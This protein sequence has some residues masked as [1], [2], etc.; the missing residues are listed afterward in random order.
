MHVHILGICGTFMAGI[1]QIAQ[2]KGYRVTGS[3]ENV[4]PPMSTLLEKSGITLTTGYDPT[5]LDTNPDLVIIGN[6]MSRGNPCVE[7]VLRD[8][9]PYIS[10]PQWLAESILQD[11]IVIAVSG[12]HGKTTTSSIVTWLLESAG[13]NPGFLIGGV[14]SNFG[15]SAR[16]TDSPYFVVEAD[17]YDS[18]FFDKRSKFIHYH[19]TVLLCNNLEFDH[20]DIFSSLADIQKEFHYLIR[21]VPGNGKIIYP[22]TDKALIETLARGC[23]TPTETFG[24]TEQCD[25]F[26]QNESPDGSSFEVVHANQV[27]GK[28]KWALLGQHNVQNALAA[29][30]C[31]NAVGVTPQEAIPALSD[32]KS[33]ARRLQL[34]GEINGVSVYDDFAHH[35]TAIHTTIAGLRARV[36]KDTRIIS[37]ME[38]RSYT[39][40]SGYHKDTLA[41]SLEESDSV[42]LYRSN[43]LTWDLAPVVDELSK[44]KQAAALPTVDEI[45]RN[46]VSQVK[47]GDHILVMSNG[48]FEGIHG[49]LLAAL[50]AKEVSTT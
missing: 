44:T 11:K 15:I 49:K 20:A 32:F 48:G 45:V 5:Q 35:P 6:A 22:K 18:A 21:T 34:R 41:A 19:P 40:R 31:V 2:Q 33:P 27:C 9:I 4:Y 38:L 1:A 37:V 28:A 47:A 8:K 16:Y 30:A 46:V 50:Q 10:G 3:D 13:K 7:R 26:T 42:Y 14:L 36:G 29:L 43:D 25:W 24:T 17:E 12:T 39:M 23:W